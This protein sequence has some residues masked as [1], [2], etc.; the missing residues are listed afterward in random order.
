MC[1][2]TRGAQSCPGWAWAVPAWLLDAVCTVP[3]A[4]EEK[5]N[6][7][8]M[9]CYFIVLDYTSANVKQNFKCCRGRQSAYG[10]KKSQT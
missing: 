8:I 2:G 4:P 6:I 1:R 5:V 10:P 7:I 3:R 9:C